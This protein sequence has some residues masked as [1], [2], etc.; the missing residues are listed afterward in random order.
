M[1]ELEEVID[2]KGLIITIF[3][4]LNFIH[5]QKMVERGL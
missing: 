4:L 5:L 1:G 3:I 2:S